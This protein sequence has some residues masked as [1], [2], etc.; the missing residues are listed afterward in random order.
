MKERIEKLEKELSELKAELSEEEFEEGQYRFC[1]ANKEPYR[2]NKRVDRR[3]YEILWLC[4]SSNKLEEVS[5]TSMENDRLLEGDE[6]KEALIAEAKRR[7]LVP[8]AVV[9]CL[10]GNG[11]G[12]VKGNKLGRVYSYWV[13]DCLW[14]YSDNPGGSIIIY[15]QGDW[16]E[17][18]EDTPTI[19]VNGYTAEFHEDY[20]E[21]GCARIDKRF[22]TDMMIE[23]PWDFEG[24][25]NGNRSMTGIKI[26]EGVFT[27]EQVK[28][29]AGYYQSKS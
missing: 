26:G 16:A 13:N 22:F 4:E 21:F 3:R 2:I 23:E 7:G 9:E 15:K 12:R 19:E 28:E 17:K 14:A 10:G 29:I 24:D 8:G 11:K 1:W 6:I 20:V 5:K 27:V 25:G 18:V